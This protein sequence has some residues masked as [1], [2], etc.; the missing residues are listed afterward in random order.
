M[1][2]EKGNTKNT[3]ITFPVEE[4]KKSQRYSKYVDVLGVV[5]EK[6]R[7]YTLEQADKAV[8]EFLKKEV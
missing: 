2:E 4:L 7:E 6:D 3:E 5:L 1:A 8:N